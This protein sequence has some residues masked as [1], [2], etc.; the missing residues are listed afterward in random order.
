MFYGSAMGLV[1]ITMI[2]VGLAMRHVSSAKALV[3][4]ATAFA[5]ITMIMFSL[6]MGFVSSAMR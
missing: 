5:I 1:I 4:L 2:I 3:R 6:A